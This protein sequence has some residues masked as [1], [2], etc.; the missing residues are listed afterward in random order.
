MNSKLLPIEWDAFLAQHPEAHLLQTTAWGDLKSSFGWTV[1]RVVAGNTGA[2]ILLRRMV[3]GMTLAYLAKGPVG[4]T[5]DNLWPEIDAVCQHRYAVFLTV[6][7]DAWIEPS[8]VDLP[9][10][11]FLPGAHSIQPPRTLLV[12]LNGD[13]DSILGRMK[14]KTRY[15]IKLAQKNGVTVRPS[16]DLQVFYRLMQVTGG[17]DKFGVHSLA[18]YQRAYDLFHTRNSCEL[19]LAEFEQEPLAA[20]MVFAHGK[21][22]W[23]LY[24]ASSSEHRDRM[25]TYLLQWEAI[26][27]ARDHGCT[28]YDLWGVPDADENT[29]ETEFAQRSGGLW[30]VYRNKRGFGGQ[31]RRA[32]GPWDRVYSP[33]AYRLY[34]WWISRRSSIKN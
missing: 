33:L 29:L 26:R 31:L 12:D 17:R 25:P 6:E 1:E 20:L 7:P 9:P 19:L 18:Y 27:W 30:G 4:E 16:A 21:R 22:A 24:G 8:K 32:A 5:W 3:P 14:Q 13:E 11:G 23:Y 2:Q 34:N 28:Q 15:N 10:A